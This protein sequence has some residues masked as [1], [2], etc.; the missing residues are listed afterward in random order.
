MTKKEKIA[1][2][3]DEQ[4][5]I[6]PIDDIVAE[7]FGRYAKYIILERALPDVRDGLKPV[8]RR[9]L[10]AMNDLGLTNDKAYK[11]AARV[12]GEVIGKYH[13]HGD[14]AVYAAM[15]RMA[16]EWK[17]AWPLIQMHGN[18]GS[19]DGDNPAAMRYTEA[20]L[21]AIAQLLLNDINKETVAFINNFDESELEPV[22]LPAYFPNLLVNGASG[23][24]VGMATNI[25][26]HNLQEVINALIMRITNPQCTLS[27]LMKSTIKGPDFPTGGIIQGLKGIKDAYNTGKGRIAIRAKTIINNN[28]KMP[29]IIITEIPYEVV[30]QDLVKK[31]DEI[32]TLQKIHGIKE[33]RDETDRSGLRIVLDLTPDSKPDEICNYLFK[34]TNLQIY[35]N[36][37]LVAIVNKKPC[38]MSLINMLDFYIN[39]QIM[40]VTR[41]AKYDKEQLEKRLEIVT[42]LVLALSHVDQ[43]IKIIKSSINSS[44]AKFNLIATFNF[45]EIQ[46]EAIIQLRLY[47]LTATDIEAL[48]L[49]KT[50][51]ESKIMALTAMLN[52]NEILKQAI[53]DQ[54][55]LLKTNFPLSRRSLI[56]GE[57]S[58]IT[59]NEKATLREE[60]VFITIS[61]DGWIKVIN[62][63]VI[64]QNLDYQHFG[65]KPND[66]IIGAGLMNNFNN[67]LLFTNKGNYLLIPIFKLEEKKW[68]DNGIHVNTLCK[69][70][71]DEKII[72]VGQINNFDQAQLNLVVVTKHGLI[73]RMLLS[74]LTTPRINKT[75]KYVKLKD[76][77]SVVAV[78]HAFGNEFVIIT[79]KNGL[80]LKYLV[81]KIP[82]L[83]RSAAGVKALKINI[84]E[85]TIVGMAIGNSNDIY[86]IVTSVGTIKRILFSTIEQTARTTKGNKVCKIPKNKAIKIIKTFLCSNEAIINILNKNE[87]WTIIAAHDIPVTKVNE[88]KGKAVSDDIMSA[89]NNLIINLDSDANL[90]LA[91]NTTENNN[92]DNN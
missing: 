51:I 65:R 27:M 66:I 52:D 18:K 39:H 83:S 90:I 57:I 9:I 79:T 49:E 20:R 38:Q 32:C 36:F 14:S 42:G 22:V 40:I 7:R 19:I 72:G 28:S 17:L 61:Y 4:I 31:I 73:K 81:S 30:K 53:I 92:N 29:Q 13:P 56:Q 91:S 89:G 74:S 88:G 44:Q 86:G 78:N 60:K 25:P 2:P 75:A 45:T 48:I 34:N 26:P 85:D 70:A 47:R 1:A 54:L 43:V 80:T 62:S 11:K 8:Q 3:I 41:R 24:A 16:Q 69:I 33:V 6:Y 10:Y 63:K 5:L 67:L 58:E 35:Y 37:N 15:C 23:I 84:L 46:A 59:I 50:N 12:V 77:D 71:G 82:V 64:A 21:S 87:Q 76:N 55:L 68:K